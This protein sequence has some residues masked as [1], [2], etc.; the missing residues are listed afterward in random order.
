MLGYVT[1]D[2]YSLAVDAGNSA[3]H[4]DKFYAELRKLG[5]RPPHFTVITP[6]HWDHTFGMCAVSGKTVAGHLTNAKLTEVQNWEWT[7]EAMQSRLR[8]GDDLELCDRCIRLEYPDRSK[9]MVV[10][11]VIEFTGRISIDLGGVSCEI[12]G[13]VALHSDDSVLVHVPERDS[14]SS[15]MPIA[16]TTT[17]TRECTTGDDRGR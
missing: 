13:F 1:G 9:V 16:R 12:R 15:A 7:D 2:R 14:P 8:A 10:R 4:V 3:D 5:L 6:W 11:A 17:G